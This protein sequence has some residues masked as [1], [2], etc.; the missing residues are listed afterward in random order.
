VPREAWTRPFG[1]PLDVR[2]VQGNVEQDMKFRPERTVAA[3]LDYTARFEAGRA[4]LTI[5]P[6]TAWTV[7]WDRTPEP[8]AQRLLEHVGRGHALALGLPEFVADPAGGEPR[9]AN[10]VLLLERDAPPRRYDKHHLVPFGEF[11]PWGFRWFVDMMR[12]PL[13]DFARGAPV[14]APFEVG[15]QRIAFDICYEDLF[16]EEI[17]RTLPGEHGATVLANVS[18]IG[19][20]GRSH[21]LPQH[22]AIARM[23]TLETGRPMLRATNTGVTA[24]IDGTGRVIA[25]LPSHEAGELDVRVQGTTGLTPFARMGN[26]VAL[27]TALLAL[28][29]AALVGARGRNR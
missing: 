21:A 14:Q 1:E 13:G 27:G 16:G 9:L 24:A 8:I 15:G 7:P 22:L 11:V 26:A 10:S 20:F 17:R 28:V 25:S 6:E 23:R 12:M 2:L 19:W 4:T 3:M 18:N 5:L 29:L